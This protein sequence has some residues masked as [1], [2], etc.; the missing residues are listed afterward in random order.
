M[1]NEF[2]YLFPLIYLLLKRDVAVFHIAKKTVLHKE[3]LLDS[4]DSLMWV[5]RA[6]NYR[7]LDLSGALLCTMS[8]RALEINVFQHFSSRTTST[9]IVE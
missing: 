8:Y 3:E 7:Y 9:W 2:Q 4:A 5:F 1:L 6:V